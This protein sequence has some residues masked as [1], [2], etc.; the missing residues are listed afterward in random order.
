MVHKLHLL[1][2]REEQELQLGHLSITNEALGT[3][4]S[5]QNHLPQIRSTS[6][7]LTL[8]EQ[9]WWVTKIVR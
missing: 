5:Y 9:S 1:C 6:I 2:Q 7:D 3:E 8:R 4:S